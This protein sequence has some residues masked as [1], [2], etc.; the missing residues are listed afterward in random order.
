MKV[1]LYMK[2]L[3]T[4]MVGQKIC[5]LKLAYRFTVTNAPKPAIP[6]ENTIINITIN[7]ILSTETVDSV[8]SMT[9][10]SPTNRSHH[11]LTVSLL[12]QGLNS[13]LSFVDC[14]NGLAY[15]IIPIVVY[16]FWYDCYH[17]GQLLC[18]IW[19]LDL[20]YERKTVLQIRYWT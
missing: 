14:A 19:S 16:M 11:R 20:T 17:I 5:T 15:P 7:N 12:G 2:V 13:H 1:F 8:V 6:V 4:M 9:S 18:I 10:Y 3:Y